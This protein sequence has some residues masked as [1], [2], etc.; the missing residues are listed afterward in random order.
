M[1]NSSLLYILKFSSDLV[2]FHKWNAFRCRFSD[3]SL[4]LRTLFKTWSEALTSMTVSHHESNICKINSFAN[5][6]LS[7]LKA[8]SA[9]LS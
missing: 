9:F 1:T 8:F 4:W 7:S 5:N 2:N 6:Y 3:L